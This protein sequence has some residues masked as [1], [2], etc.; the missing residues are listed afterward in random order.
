MK[1]LAVVLSLVL[2]ACSSNTI[3]PV[4]NPEVYKVRKALT[5]PKDVC[6]KYQN[7]RTQCK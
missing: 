3:D 7:K 5:L 2:A 6:V 4:K 1:Y